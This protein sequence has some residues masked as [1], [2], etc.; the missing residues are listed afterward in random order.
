MPVNP[1]DWQILGL[2]PTTDLRLIQRA[3]AARLKRTRPEDDA[4]AYQALRAAYD[5]ARQWALA[6]PTG[7]GEAAAPGFA[8]AAADDGGS[9]SISL[10]ADD[11][12]EPQTSEP[13]AG[14]A[15]CSLSALVDDLHASWSAGGSSAVLA[16]WAQ[17]IARFDAVPL[18]QRGQLQAAVAD[19]VLAREAV[20]PDL[21]LALS[22]ALGWRGDFRTARDLGPRRALA[23]QT[24]LD[25]ASDPSLSRPELA[26]EL[27]PLRRLSEL[28]AVGG[29]WQGLW[30]M[31]LL[32][33]NLCQRFV[34]HGAWMRSWSGLAED[35]VGALRS[36]FTWALALRCFAAVAMVGALVAALG[37][38]APVVI[39]AM[40][41]FSVLTGGIAVLATTLAALIDSAWGLLL[42]RSPVQ[43]AVARALASPYTP[44][45]GALALVLAALLPWVL[46][47][48]A[49]WVLLALGWLLGAVGV[50]ALWPSGFEQGVVSLCTAGL[51]AGLAFSLWPAAP[52]LS[53]LAATA[54]WALG[55]AQAHQRGWH[56][57]TAG[58][59]AGLAW[60]LWGAAWLPLQLLRQGGWLFAVVPFA[61]A[62]SLRLAQVLPHAA[63]LAVTWVG[64][65][66]AL[67][68][69][70]KAATRWAAPRLGLAADGS[71][72]TMRAT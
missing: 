37:A 44:A 12:C 26:A 46:G 27:L 56:Q 51:A 35:D 8:E 58:L 69:A 52:E 65:N 62:L 11:G 24:L 41:S 42:R 67:A 38:P 72:P 9:G 33:N 30:L 54:L 43:A 7:D 19:W 23:L 66:L 36:A 34:R 15:P 5:A 63:A 68:L 6:M 40:V 25:E 28:W 21:L 70:Q 22:Q 20:R 3:Y 2:E 18:A 17:W 48:V 13:Q 14:P 53:V 4:Q 50:R 32:G 60:P 39:K 59:W 29:H 55:A 49:P 57:A 47:P 61:A 45:A 1:I 31:A 64:L 71:T 10:P 16:E